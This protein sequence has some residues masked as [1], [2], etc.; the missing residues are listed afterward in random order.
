VLS[1]GVLSRL[2]LRGGLGCGTRRRNG[3]DLHELVIALNVLN[4][5]IFVVL[6][7]VGARFVVDLPTA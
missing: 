6:A 3:G 1:S 7:L 4:C 5:V 2:R